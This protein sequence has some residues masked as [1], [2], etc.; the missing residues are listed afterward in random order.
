MRITTL[1]QRPPADAL[2]R[3]PGAAAGPIT[4]PAAGLASSDVPGDV[5][6]RAAGGVSG[7]IASSDR[8]HVHGVGDGVSRARHRRIHHASASPDADRATVR[9]RRHRANATGSAHARRPRHGRRRAGRRGV[10]WLALRTARR[11]ISWAHRRGISW[12]RRRGV[13]WAV[14][15]L[16]VAAGV[17][18]ILASIPEAGA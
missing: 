12:A 15:A 8:V 1:C 10:C 16:V 4:G 3:E 6:I 5:A 7:L 2:A 18:A 17:G 9:G 14:A 13:S 11:G